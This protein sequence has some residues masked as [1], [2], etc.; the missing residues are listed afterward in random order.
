ML[1]RVLNVKRSTIYYKP[2]TNEEAKSYKH[3]LDVQAVLQAFNENRRKYGSRKIK[4]ELAKKN[5]IFSRRKICNIMKEIGI[6]SC[7]NTKSYRH[8]ASGCN[9]KSISNVIDRHFDCW[10][11]NEVIVSD[12]TYVNVGGKWNYVCNLIDLYNR[13]IVGFSVGEQK[14]AELVKEAFDNSHIDFNKMMIFHTDRGREFDNRLI[15][16]FLEEHSVIRSLSRKGTPYDNAVSESTFKIVK[17]EFVKGK[18]FRDIEQLR[19]EYGD[20]VHWFNNCRIHSSLNYM[21]PVE[22]KNLPL[23]NIA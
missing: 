6:R 16:N 14:T 3:S 17:T 20:Y 10:K 22:Y 21:T 13:E 11:K 9:E 1:C 12:L 15:D 23:I 7:Y 2:K 4:V 18:T 5:I 19:L 8:Y